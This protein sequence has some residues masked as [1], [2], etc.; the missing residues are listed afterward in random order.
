MVDGEKGPG[1]QNEDVTSLTSP[2]NRTEDALTDALSARSSH[3]TPTADII[4]MKTAVE[5]SRTQIAAS[6]AVLARL[7]N[8]S[9]SDASC[10][11][12]PPA[13]PDRDGVLQIQQSRT[14]LWSDPSAAPAGSSPP[15][16]TRAPDI[17]ECAFRPASAAADDAEGAVDLETHGVHLFDIADALFSDSLVDGRLRY[18]LAP[19]GSVEEST[20]IE[21][22]RGSAFR[23]RSKSVPPSG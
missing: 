17:I 18:M 19:H 15:G 1:E 9:D 7:A 14:V 12:T 11:V 21:Q 20:S 2:A 23:D 16:S 6:R 22:Q 10:G 8:A 4:A 5:D 3:R 13:V